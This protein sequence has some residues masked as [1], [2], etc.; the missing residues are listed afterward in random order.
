MN[1]TVKKAVKRPVGTSS[2]AAKAR[3]T[4]TTKRVSGRKFN[5]R[6]DLPDGFEIGHIVKD[7]TKI[8]IFSRNDWS[9]SGGSS[10]ENFRYRAQN[11]NA[12]IIVF[13]FFSPTS[14]FFQI[15]FYERNAEVFIGGGFVQLGVPSNSEFSI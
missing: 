2:L 6:L 11:S 12:R 10:S 13:H 4:L 9:R 7:S 5:A 1:K 15:H 8:I 3:K 14:F